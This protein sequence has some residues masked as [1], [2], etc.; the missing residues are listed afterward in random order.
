MFNSLYFRGYEDDEEGDGSRRIYFEN[1][2]NVKD[3]KKR[4]MLNFDKL[5]KNGFV[6]L[7]VTDEDAIIGKVGEETNLN[8]QKIGLVS[9]KSVKFNTSG[10]VDKVVVTKNAEK[11]KKSKSK[12]KEK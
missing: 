11:F 6:V 3:I 5:D 1:P 12:N 10:Y 2:L 9:G 7:S 8:N 4:N